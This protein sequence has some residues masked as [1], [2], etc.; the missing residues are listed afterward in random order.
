MGG[1]ARRKSPARSPVPVEEIA[2]G[3]A[4]DVAGL[5][6][7]EPVT[8]VYNPLEYAWAPHCEYLNR[9]GG[10]QGVALLVGMNPGPWGMAQT[11]VPFGEV[12]MVR[13]WM[14]IAGAIG[15]PASE[16]PKRPI[17]GFDCHRAEVSGARLWGWARDRY[18]EADAFFDRFFV[19]NYCPLSFMVASGAN[20]TPDKLGRAERDSLFAICDQALRDVVR[21]IRPRMIVGIGKF[22]EKRAAAVVGDDVPVATVLHPSP[23]SPLANRGWAGAAERQL[24]KL[25]LL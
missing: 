12:G 14:K 19:W 4:R 25:G 2:A 17:L 1:P 20:F 22:A 21:A 13:D 3:L 10:R 7:S 16:H 15:R 11:G 9:F 6:F 24:E 18:G 5:T 23:A 8:H